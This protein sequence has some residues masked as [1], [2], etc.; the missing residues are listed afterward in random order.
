MAISTKSFVVRT[1]YLSDV[2]RPVVNPS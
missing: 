1:T 2:R